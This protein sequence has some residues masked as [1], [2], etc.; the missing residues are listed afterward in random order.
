MG[1]L[2]EIFKNRNLIWEGMKN[3]LFKREHIE[4]VY[5]ERLEICKTCKLFDLSGEG[6]TIPGTRTML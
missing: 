1:K 3:N 5:H 6:C 2:M 4:E